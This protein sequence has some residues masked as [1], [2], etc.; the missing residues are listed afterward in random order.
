MSENIKKEIRH[1]ISEHIYPIPTAPKQH[2]K[3]AKKGIR[4]GDNAINSK[5]ISM[6]SEIED[7][8]TLQF[9]SIQAFRR[10]QIYTCYKYSNDKLSFIGKKMKYIITLLKERNLRELARK[11]EE[12]K[13]KWFTDILWNKVLP[14]IEE[15]KS[16][17]TVKPNKTNNT[18]ITD[19]PGII[20]YIRKVDRDTLK[21]ALREIL[22]ILK[23]EW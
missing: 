23:E 13:E 9:A 2:S 4:V 10:L 19:I 21:I 3:K 12:E 17:K 18:D 7:K 20:Q 11:L 8:V 15:I 22:D 16:S 5:K 6:L 14:K 1:V